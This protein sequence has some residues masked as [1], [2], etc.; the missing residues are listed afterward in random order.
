[1]AN[2]V[3]LTSN[4]KH[5]LLNER[6]RPTT[7]DGYVGN[8]QLKTTIA[9]YLEQND[10]QNY[11]FHGQAGTGKTTLA[12]IVINNL[13][14][15][16]LYINASD[17]RG[18]ETIRDKVVG[19]ASVASFKPLKVVILDEADFLTIQAQA[20]LRNVIETYSKSTRFIL[21]CNFIER[22]IDPLQ[23]R[24]QTFKIQA[25]TKSD[26]AKHLVNILETEKTNFDLE[27]IKSLVNQYYP[28]I[29]K[30][31]NT[32]QA[33]TIDNTLSLDKSTLSS[34]SYMSDVLKELT[35]DKPNYTTIRQI[36][37]DAEVSDFDG[38]YRYL[39]DNSDQYLPNKQGTVAMIIN[40]HQYQSN[41]RIDKE[42]NTMSLIQNLINN[43]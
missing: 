32:I 10:I 5:T 37:A 24:C 33:S 23:S 14:C 28:D 29:R 11:L 30:M 22:I 31:L 2:S 42:I 19:F 7:L 15:E 20:S 21:T 17:E 40:E 1:M 18:I 39:F 34:T 9:K 25:P 8:E 4:N 41:F 3:R 43:K 38:L 12:K 16:S 6:Y 35:L 36:I 13:D 26:V 27:Q